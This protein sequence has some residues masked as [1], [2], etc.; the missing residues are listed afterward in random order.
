M[1]I[2]LRK[3][4]RCLCLGYRRK[5][6][7]LGVSG[8][9]TAAVDTINVVRVSAQP[10]RIWLF[11]QVKA[12]TDGVTLSAVWSR[13]S[14]FAVSGSV[15]ARVIQ[16]YTDVLRCV[17]HRST[18]LITKIPARG[19]TTLKIVGKMI[20]SGIARQAR[21][22]YGEDS[23][24]RAT[25]NEVERLESCLLDYKMALVG[26]CTSETNVMRRAVTDEVVA[27]G[28]EISNGE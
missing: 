26:K 1:L 12:A 27:N 14:G 16:E 24:A 4:N 17:Y 20:P 22:S 7:E 21:R 10:S 6:V 13:M 25:C 8:M 18:R 15:F 23:P 19:V 11:V 28:M 2:R 5:E 9:C 3:R